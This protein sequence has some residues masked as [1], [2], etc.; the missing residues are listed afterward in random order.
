MGRKQGGG[1]KY[2]YLCV[3]SLTVFV[4]GCIALREIPERREDRDALARAQVLLS[5]GD[6]EGSLRENQRVLSMGAK[7]SGGDEAL[8][9]MGLIY[10]HAGNPKRD[11]LRAM[12]FFGR[13]PKEYPQS[14]LVGQAKIWV[15]VLQANEKLTQMLE[16]SKQ[17]DGESRDAL[18]RA[19]EL[20]SQGDY[21]GSLRENQRV[22]S[23]TANESPGDE[24]VFN[25]GLIYA[26]AGNP[27][28]DYRKAMSFFGR[29]PKEYPQSPLAGQA[30]IW[31]GVL[32]ANEKLT[33]MLEK[34]KQVDIEIE[35]KR[36][37]R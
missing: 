27:K 26:H 9:N 8:F 25:M 35:E 33:Q 13:L 14:P 23:L 15:G 32:Q 16:K 21:E 19:Q 28:K 10:A 36:R 7:A 29:L 1:R 11:Y 6:Y 12:G 20:L 17:V 37:E 22:L 3:V 5:Q 34:S 18:A 4:S 2:I 24:A 30:K 31:L